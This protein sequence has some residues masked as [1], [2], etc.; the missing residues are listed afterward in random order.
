M[1]PK[2]T[3]LVVAPEEDITCTGA[4]TVSGLSTSTTSTASGAP[5]RKAARV[6]PSVAT[7]NDNNNNNKATDDS[8]SLI[9]SIV[10]ASSSASSS[11]APVAGAKP[12]GA[13]ADSMG[14]ADSEGAE[15]GVSVLKDDTAERAK[16]SEAKEAALLRQGEELSGD[17][18]RRFMME[19]FLN[20]DDDPV[21]DLERILGGF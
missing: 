18:L 17:A 12:M 4:P 20:F 5:K 8:A 13:I 19:K 14:L 7:A 3:K 1:P 16:A 9:D 6:E 15:K 2:R 11:S 21:S 10:G